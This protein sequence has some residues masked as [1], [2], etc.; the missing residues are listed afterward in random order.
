MHVTER[1]VASRANAVLLV[2]SNYSISRS[3]AHLAS[4]TPS[5]HEIL[6]RIMAFLWCY[7]LVGNRSHPL[8]I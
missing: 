6:S 5:T 2:H 7:I 1:N 3:Q 8:E 4:Q